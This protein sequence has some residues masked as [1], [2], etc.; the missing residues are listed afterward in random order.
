MTNWK[1][2]RAEASIRE[3]TEKIMRSAQSLADNDE[4]LFPEQI[5]RANEVLSNTKLPHESDY[6][7]ICVGI[8]LNQFFPEYIRIYPENNEE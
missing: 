4:S 6:I 8:G 1:N 7:E 3:G 5:K 2:D